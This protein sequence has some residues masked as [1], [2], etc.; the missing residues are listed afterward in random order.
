MESDA[1]R[2][3]HPIYPIRCKS[4]IYIALLIFSSAPLVKMNRIRV[5]PIYMRFYPR[6]V[7]ALGNVKHPKKPPC[8]VV[9]M[10]AKHEHSRYTP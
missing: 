8:Q 3:M 9:E 4:L 2:L 5:Y 7:Y 10:D 1:Q 6:Y